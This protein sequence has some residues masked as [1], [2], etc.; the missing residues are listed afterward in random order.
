[1]LW[2]NLAIRLRSALVFRVMKYDPMNP[3]EPAE[4]LAID[5]EERLSM[6]FAYLDEIPEPIENKQV[7]G[8]LLTLTENQVAMGDE[9]PVKAAVDRLEMEGLDRFTALLAVQEVFG[10]MMQ[11]MAQDP[12]SRYSF[13]LHK[14]RLA[15][16]DS[17]VWKE[18]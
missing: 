15:K 3:I 2:Q 7:L 13:E 4:W 6:V 5:E 1:M 14:K 11:E 16:I 8:M 12:S 10:E 17:K 9:T 18:V